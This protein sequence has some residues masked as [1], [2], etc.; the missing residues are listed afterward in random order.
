ML[1]NPL[2]IINIKK[3]FSNRV[4]LDNI[5][6]HIGKNEIFGLVGLN[7][8]GKTTLIKIILSLLNADSGI[9][10]ILGIDST[11]TK[12]REKLKYLP[13]KF[14]VSSMLKGIEFLKIFNSFSQHTKI[15]KKELEDE[16]FR[17]ANILE[18]NRELL[19]MRV[20][21]YS[22]GMTQKLG[23]ISTFLG[24]YELVI[25]DEP[26]SGLDPKARINLKNLLLASK[27]K[28]KSIFFSSHILSDIDEICDK[29]AVLD[30]GQLCFVGTPEELKNKHSQKSLEKAFLKEISQNVVTSD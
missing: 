5:S 14:Q 27:E 8:V 30:K 2:E 29:I 12:S 15:D 17:L 16:I 9:V 19:Y 22:K 21:K 24:N 11:K 4:I 26:M 18:L 1:N 25:L 20:S 28:G 3:S 23:L 6:L 7:G 10:K 13:E